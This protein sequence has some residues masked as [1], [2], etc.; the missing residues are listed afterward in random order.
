MLF[1]EADTNYEVFSMSLAIML[2]E[3]AHT[4]ADAAKA[5]R[6]PAVGLRPIALLLVTVDSRIDHEYSC[7]IRSQVRRTSSYWLLLDREQGARKWLKAQREEYG[8]GR[9]Q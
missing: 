7:A 3:E 4:P 1:T 8:D 5:V 2:G 6:S 9:H